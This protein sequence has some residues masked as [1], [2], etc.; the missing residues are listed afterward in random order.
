MFG[1]A[2]AADLCDITAENTMNLVRGLILNALHGTRRVWRMRIPSHMAPF[3]TKR[4][5]KSTTSHLN[6][7]DDVAERM[8]ILDPFANEGVAL[9]FA[10]TRRNR[11]EFRTRRSS[12]ESS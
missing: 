6:A 8:R 7:Q 2:Y 11:Y 5:R 1:Q 4:R 10:L 9:D 12:L 3:E